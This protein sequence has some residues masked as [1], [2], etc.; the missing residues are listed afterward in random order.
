[1]LVKGT[2]KEVWLELVAFV[3]FL[4]NSPMIAKR[5]F[6]VTEGNKSISSWIKAVFKKRWQSLEIGPL[7]LIR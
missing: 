2:V 4:Q 1:M 5:S 6:W 3:E 7:R